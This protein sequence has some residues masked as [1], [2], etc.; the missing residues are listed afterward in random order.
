[1]QHLAAGAATEDYI[2]RVAAAPGDQAALTGETLGIWE[3]SPVVRELED[4]ERGPSTVK[5]AVVCAHKLRLR[6]RLVFL[7]SED[8]GECMGG[9]REFG[10]L[11]THSINLVSIECR[12]DQPLSS[13]QVFS[14][15]LRRSTQFLAAMSATS[16][17][18]CPVSGTE[19]GQAN[20][21]LVPPVQ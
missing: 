14:N 19:M 2:F 21:L 11:L 16:C 1:M 13:L 6:C 18:F 17:G 5:T 10:D 15:R 9:G 3:R 8:A 12:L 20:K 4:T 7:C